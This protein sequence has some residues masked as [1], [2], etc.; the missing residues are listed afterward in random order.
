[1]LG[2]ENLRGLLL[3]LLVV[4]LSLS[5]LSGKLWIQDCS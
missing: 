1:M 4:F 3:Q 2:S 5:G